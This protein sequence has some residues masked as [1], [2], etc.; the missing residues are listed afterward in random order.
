HLLR[1]LEMDLTRRDN[2]VL[3]A[4]LVLAQQ[5]VPGFP[6][7]SD[8]RPACHGGFKA[9][10]T[11]PEKLREVWQQYRGPLIGV[12]TG[13]V[14]GFN[15]LDLDAKHDAAKAWW[16]DNRGRLPPTRIHR[17]RSGGLHALFRHDDTMQCTAGRIAVRIY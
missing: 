4:A 2:S 5:G 3:T 13:T 12:P 10:T 11:D 9:A 8:K 6:C 17:T 7:L 1:L 14:S 16:H 15:A